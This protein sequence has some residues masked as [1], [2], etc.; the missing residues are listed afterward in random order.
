MIVYESIIKLC[1]EVGTDLDL[2]GLLFHLDVRWSLLT[3]QF[4]TRSQFFEVFIYFVKEAKGTFLFSKTLVGCHRLTRVLSSPYYTNTPEKTSRKISFKSFIKI[5][6]SVVRF[7][8]FWQNKLIGMSYN[9][10]FSIQSVPNKCSV[11]FNT[12]LF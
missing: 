8:S 12:N 11:F 5:F 7:S 6:A 2:F 1:R 9:L 10:N 3:T 4:S